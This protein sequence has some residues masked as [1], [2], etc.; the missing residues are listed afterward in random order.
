MTAESIRLAIAYGWGFVCAMALAW[1]IMR[2][3]AYEEMD[4]AW[5]LAQA[6]KRANDLKHHHHLMGVRFARRLLAESD[7]DTDP[8]D[9]YIG[10]REVVIVRQSDPASRHPLTTLPA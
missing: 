2:R 1:I 4:Q 3:S 10:E 9:R 8:L 5:R 6:Y 7:Y